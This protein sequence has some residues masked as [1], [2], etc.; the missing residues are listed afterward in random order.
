MREERDALKSSLEETSDKLKILQEQSAPLEEKLRNLT[1]TEEKS[2]AEI[3]AL[4]AD[5]LRWRQRVN[6]L[7]EKE[8]K[9]NPEEMSKLQNEN[10]VQKRKIETL[11]SQI[12]TL[13][14]RC[15]DIIGKLKT[16]D[17]NFKNKD[18]ECK[19]AL[20]DLQNTK[21]TN[22]TLA[23]R[24]SIMTKK[25]TELETIS[26]NLVKEK[27]ALNANMQKIDIEHKTL[28]TKHQEFN[29]NHVKIAKELEEVKT[30]NVQQKKTIESFKVTN[31]KLKNL[32]RSLKSQLE[33]SKN[34][35]KTKEAEK[36]VLETTL[37]AVNEAKEVTSAAARSGDSDQDQPTEEQ[38]LLAASLAQIKD[39]EEKVSKLEQELNT[40]SEQNKKLLAD[41]E[42]VKPML[43]NAKTK[44]ATL[45]KEKEEQKKQCDNL[46][47]ENEALT[48]GRTN[49]VIKKL[50]SD[51]LTSKND[52]EKVKADHDKE[53][54]DLT[55]KIE[56][57]SKAKVEAK[58]SDPEDVQTGMVKPVVS[59]A[60]PQKAVK[61]QPQ[62]QVQPTR[63]VVQQPQTAKVGP[64]SRQVQVSRQQVASV[65]PSSASTLNPSAPE[66]APQTAPVAPAA[67]MEPVNKKNFEIFFK[68]FK[69]FFFFFNFL[70]S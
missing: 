4:K 53:K 1:E 64:I 33:E 17:S 52:L 37:K 70:D 34:A 59:E 60:K 32:G 69:L 19:K 14:T 28:V 35:L 7:I 6:Q 2:S 16:L 39:L 66:F 47:K 63:H 10:G 12:Q 57:L 8:Q 65:S 42:R 3:S 15:N 55:K 67:S 41:K 20:Q 62:A 13:K 54:E 43:Q 50:R 51:L 21:V 23:S 9:I 22:Q 58:K 44:I 56:E 11:E 45:V 46:Q 27:E 40:I 49:E 36:E 24:M 25:T 31:D 5:N 30:Q 38:E 18:E 48:K 29:E 68:F 26:Q 61:A